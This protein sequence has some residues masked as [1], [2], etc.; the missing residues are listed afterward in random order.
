MKEDFTARI[1]SLDE[2]YKTT[3]EL[4]QNI[5]NSGISFDIVV[6]IARGGALPAR[7]IC[8]FLNI[9]RLTSLQIK[10]YQEGAEKMEEAK[11]IDP[12]S[13]DIK[14]QN[15]LLIDDVN[16]SGETMK[17]AVDHV[18]SIEPSLLK[19]A[20]L[21]EKS[22][23]IFNADFTAK[24]LKKW[25]WLI[26]QWAATE[27]ILEFLE[28]DNMLDQSEEIIHKHLANKYDLEIDEQLLEKI[29]QLKENY[30]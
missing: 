15:V 2:V 23:T 6:A 16:D 22:H 13:G 7:L 25:K 3:H 26:Y 10:H 28:K 30:R 14:K 18:Q 21:H 24:K 9:N 27:D 12:V 11:I 20:V 1:V 5:M 4:A 8:D 17:A 19:T 29:M